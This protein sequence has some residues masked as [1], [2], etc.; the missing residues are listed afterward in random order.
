MRILGCESYALPTGEEI[1]IGMTGVF[2][3][4]EQLLRDVYVRNKKPYTMPKF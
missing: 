4:D 1:Y 3:R 2:I